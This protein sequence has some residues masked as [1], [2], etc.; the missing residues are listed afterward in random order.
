MNF[1]K[2]TLLLRIEGDH[3]FVARTFYD[4]ATEALA[5]ITEA[6]VY[7]PVY[8]DVATEG[9]GTV[10]S[11]PVKPVEEVGAMPGSKGTAR[12]VTKPKK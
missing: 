10:K 5:S 4:S 1:E 7:L 9:P 8:C 11:L 3:I 2:K 12:K 6:G